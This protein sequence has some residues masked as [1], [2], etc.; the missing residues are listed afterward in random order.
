MIRFGAIV[1][2]VAV[3][4][5]LLIAG[6]VSGE[7]PLVYVSIGLAAL[8]LLM[9]I[10]GVAVWRD[11]VFGATAATQKTLRLGS[12][13]AESATA[14]PAGLSG[15]Q[16]AADWPGDGRHDDEVAVASGNSARRTAGRTLAATAGDTRATA[17]PER[18]RADRE[19]K[20][21]ERAHRELVDRDQ[22]GWGGPGREA[23]PANRP[24]PETIQADV[25]PVAAATGRLR[26]EEVETG[27]ARRHDPAAG[28]S[29]PASPVPVGSSRDT[30]AKTRSIAAA[31]AGAPVVE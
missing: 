15:R 25:V 30:A 3:A 26:A 28:F 29:P 22:P 11:E 20:H 13:E 10:A 9:L 4:I 31:A 1:S 19:Q 2:V 17:V 18:E 12:D 27:R 6:A 23:G 8:A 14:R 24:L 7:L 5:G 16:A 21:R